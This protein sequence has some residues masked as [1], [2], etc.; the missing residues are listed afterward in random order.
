[1]KTKRLLLLAPFGACLLLATVHSAPPDAQPPAPPRAGDPAPAAPAA[2]TTPAAEPEGRNLLAN[3]DFAQGTGRW[4]L[5]NWG[6]RTHMKIDPAETHD[7]HPAL[8]VDNFT[9]AHS[10]VRQ[11]LTGKV[12]THYRLSGF[13]KTRDI[14]ASQQTQTTGA[15]LMAGHLGAYSPLLAGTNDWTPASIEFDT[16]ATDPTI[17]V[18]PS[19]G[20]DSSFAS[21]TAWYAELKLVEV[22]DPN[23]HAQAADFL[24]GS[25]AALL[26]AGVHVLPAPGDAR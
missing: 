13:I 23:R 19:L 10:F 26:S 17:R 1:M 12:R 8:R 15:V 5:M 9:V 25:F 7:G 6:K 21:G 14:R 4:E 2:P 22:P 11:T 24:H 16:A 18:G 20:T 3:G